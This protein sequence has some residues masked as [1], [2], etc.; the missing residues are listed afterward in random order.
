MMF[1]LEH[2]LIVCSGADGPITL[3]R[4]VEHVASF[5]RLLWGA[6]EWLISLIVQG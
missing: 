2:A 5:G 4:G 6:L 1:L 3:G